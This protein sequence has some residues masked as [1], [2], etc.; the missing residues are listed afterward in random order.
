M[1]PPPP[2]AVGNTALCGRNLTLHAM[3]I[4]KMYSEIVIGVNQQKFMDVHVKSDKFL[5]QTF[6]RL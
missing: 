2:Q 1:Y 6:W 4:H 5:F 3:K